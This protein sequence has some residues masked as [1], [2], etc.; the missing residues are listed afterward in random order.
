MD[1][2]YYPEKPVLPL[3]S[4]HL[5]ILKETLGRPN[6]RMCRYEYEGFYTVFTLVDSTTKEEL[7]R[8][9][10]RY[11]FCPV[12]SYEESQ[13]QKDKWLLLFEMHRNGRECVYDKWISGSRY[14]ISDAPADKA[15][16]YDVW[17]FLKRKYILQL[18]NDL[19]NT[20]S[21]KMKRFFNQL[22]TK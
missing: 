7:L 2:N 3:S 18:E 9:R 1:M 21:Y 5:S 11:I 8:L 20:I 6:I 4:D 10:F 17:N 14:N 13:G 12:H 22:R 15:V 16:Y 19:K